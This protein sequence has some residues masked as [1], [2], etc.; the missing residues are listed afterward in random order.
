MRSER[1]RAAATM[2]RGLVGAWALLAAAGIGAVAGQ[3]EAADPPDSSDVRAPAAD[4]APGEAGAD[5]TAA[6]SAVAGIDQVSYQ[7]EVFDYPAFQRRDPFRP[8]LGGATEGPRFENLVLSGV[9]Y[10][11]TVGSVAV[12]VDRAT[13]RRHRVREGH[14]LGELR[15]D[16][17][18]RAEVE[19]L[20]PA[21]AGRERRVLRVEKQREE[22]EG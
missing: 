8:R 4:N 21:P 11:P 9:I 22:S 6:D 20:V 10:N 18:R 15:I 16:V 7:R 3:E 12:L 13:G 19:I 1:G 2:A 17:I 14:R 5:T